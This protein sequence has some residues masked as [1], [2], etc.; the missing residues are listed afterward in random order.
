MYYNNNSSS[1]KN[2]NNNN[3]MTPFVR[4]SV[5]MATFYV[6]VPALQILVGGGSIEDANA[7]KTALL[8]ER[9]REASDAN[10]RSSSSTP[11]PEP[12]APSSF[13]TTPTPAQ[14]PQRSPPGVRPS[15]AAENSV[16]AK[17]FKDLLLERGDCSSLESEVEGGSHVVQ[18]VYNY[19]GATAVIWACDRT[20]EKMLEVRVFMVDTVPPERVEPLSR[21]IEK[22]N[23]NSAVGGFKFGEATIKNKLRTCIKVYLLFEESESKNTC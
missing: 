19:K 15:S 11:V 23:T 6:Y 17:A 1:N 16:A 22:V 20:E 7:A 12:V 2:N 3:N 14:A 10:S 4:F 8:E 18:G 13:S 21:L 9:R 5:F